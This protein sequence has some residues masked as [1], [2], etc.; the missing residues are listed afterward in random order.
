MPEPT[1]RRPAPLAEG[2][3]IAAL[4]VAATLAL[5]ADLFE[6]IEV[7]TI[8]ARYVRNRL[9]APYDKIILVTIDDDD[10]AALGEWPWPRRFHGEIVRRLKS[11]G[12]RLI[13][14]D[15][16]FDT[17]STNAADDAA[18]V[19]ACREAGNVIVARPFVGEGR[20]PQ[21]EDGTF[22]IDGANLGIIGSLSEI[23]VIPELA[24]AVRATGIVDLDYAALNSDGIIRCLK[25]VREAGSGLYP[26]LGLEIARLWKGIDRAALAVTSDEVTLGADSVPLFRHLARAGGT[27]VERSAYYIRYTGPRQDAFHTVPYASLIRGRDV[28]PADFRDR[29]VIVGATAAALYD[30]KIT[31]FG[32]MPGMYLNA[33]IARGLIEGDH[34]RRPGR[35]A[36]AALLAGLALLLF[37]YVTRIRPTWLDLVALA[38]FALAWWGLA[39]SVFRASL[40]LLDVVAPVTLAA[41]VVVI[42]RFWQMFIRLHLTNLEL[43]RANRKL[44]ERVN[45]LETLHDLSESLQ[46]V[47]DMKKVYHVILKKALDVTDATVG[48][49]YLYDEKT[50]S[51]RVEDAIAP[52]EFGSP[53]FE[54]E[55]CAVALRLIENRRLLNLARGSEG[56]AALDLSDERI[57]SL[58]LAPF[59]SKRGDLLGELVLVRPAGARPFDREDERIVFLISSQASSVIE[60]TSLYLMAVTDGLTGLYVRRYFDARLGHEVNR[61]R[62][63]G[64]S[65]SLV[66]IDI[67]HFKKFNDTWGHQI[68]DAVLRETAKVVNGGLREVDLAARYGGEEMCVLLPETNLDGA[69][70]VA[71]RI[72]RSVEKHAVH[73]PKGPL[74]VTVSLGVAEYLEAMGPEELMRRADAALYHSKEAGRNRATPWTEALGAAEGH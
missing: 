36:T 23:D 71:E 63:Y 67:D 47:N 18:F 62:R 21:A 20:P 7:K 65:F 2:V 64:G 42:V 32:D 27:L 26:S 70:P 60:N 46:Q 35:G 58:L 29:V 51:V 12:A 69:M 48:Y 52:P 16:F 68:G 28:N 57:G 34:V 73:G 53:P 13:A 54:A 4:L 9:A 45:E 41:A 37:V 44:D 43:V 1:P 50:E 14:F 3:I 25:L 38:L 61:H 74:Q 39:L 59:T 19:E 33:L 11:Y 40:L 5:R 15:C 17:P 31:P 72:R 49:L 22:V 24:A 6:S 10:L 8:D 55:I 30:T 56:F 66:M